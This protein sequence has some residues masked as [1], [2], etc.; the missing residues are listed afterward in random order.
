MKRG[1]KR[2]VPPELWMLWSDQKAFGTTEPLGWVHTGDYFIVCL[3]LE[4]ARRVARVFKADHQIVSRPVKVKGA[5][6]ERK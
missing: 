5:T 1:S 6:D 4:E 3:S 2:N